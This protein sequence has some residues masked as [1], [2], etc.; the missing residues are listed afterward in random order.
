MIV[1]RA[2]PSLNVEEREVV[3]PP[4]VP[5]AVRRVVQLLEDRY[6]QIA[7]RPHPHGEAER[8]ARDR[9]APTLPKLTSVS[10]SNV[11][12]RPICPTSN[13]GSPVIVRP[14]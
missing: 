7:A 5:A 4:L 1:S 14:C 9:S 2:G 12:A 8:L 11:A 10:P 13:V 3:E 6:R